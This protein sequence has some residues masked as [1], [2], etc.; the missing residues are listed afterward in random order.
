MT[1]WDLAER[2]R[3]LFH[4]SNGN[5]SDFCYATRGVF[6]YRILLWGASANYQFFRAFKLQKQAIRI[7]AQ[8][9][10]RETCKEAFKKT[11][12]VDSAVSL[13]PRDNL[14]CMSKCAMTRGRDIHSYGTRGR[15]TYRTGSHRTGVYEHLPSQAGVRFL[16]KLPNSIKNAPTPKALKARLKRFLASQAFYSAD[17]FMAFDWVTAQLEH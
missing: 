15:D 4:W 5:L 7:I 14:F 12:T 11:A 10:F 17:E 9:R 6:Y 3:I 13:H 16:N 8:L 1:P 2:Q